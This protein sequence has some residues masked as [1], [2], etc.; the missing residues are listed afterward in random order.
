MKK[1]VRLDLLLHK[2]FSVPNI[3]ALLVAEQNDCLKK[4]ALH[5]DSNCCSAGKVWSRS[6]G[7]A[8]SL[9]GRVT[10]LQACVGVTNENCSK[11]LHSFV[12]MYLDAYKSF[13]KK[14]EKDPKARPP[15]FRSSKESFGLRF[16]SSIF[17]LEFL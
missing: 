7:E 5:K 17:R 1:E 14:H 13:H 4:L 15:G 11:T 8:K 16:E 10:N 2:I 3:Q 12:G 9:H 6:C